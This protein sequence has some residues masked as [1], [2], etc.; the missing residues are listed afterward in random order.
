[1]TRLI[2]LVWLFVCADA[3]A[4]TRKMPEALPPEVQIRLLRAQLEYAQ[5]DAAMK[6]AA[7]RYASFQ[8]QQVKAAAALQREIE[9]ARKS[10][11]EGRELDLE[12]MTCIERKENK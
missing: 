8:Q 3:A 6:D 1:M 2:A 10:C 9:Q 11:A 4:Q 5:L 7:L 12:R